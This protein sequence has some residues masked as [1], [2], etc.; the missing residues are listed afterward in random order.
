MLMSVISAWAVGGRDRSS[1]RGQKLRAG[2]LD[3]P[4]NR[5]LHPGGSCL[6]L[7]SNSRRALAETD[8]RP[9]CTC[10]LKA[11]PIQTRNQDWKSRYRRCLKSRCV[12]R[13]AQP[14]APNRRA[15]LQSGLAGNHAFPTTVAAFTLL[16]YRTPPSARSI[17][18]P[19]AYSENEPQRKLDLPVVESRASDLTE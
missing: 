16:H 1:R 10:F 11:R 14:I 17:V 19:D 12:R 6:R 4:S 2:S 5:T 18:P 15:D 13:K 9:V 8:V 7:N 3:L